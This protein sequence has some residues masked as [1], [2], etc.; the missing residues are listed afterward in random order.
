MWMLAAWATVMVVCSIL[1]YASE[2]G[3]NQAF[4]DPLDAL[5]WGISTLTTVGY[6][7]VYPVTSEGRLAAMT[8][9]ILGIGLYSA[10]TAA[11]TSYFV[12]G[13]RQSDVADELERLARLHDSGKLTEGEYA[14]AKA[15]VLD[16]S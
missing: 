12:A 1:L 14:S 5:W 2:V 4:D 7:D 16:T 11:I 8:L 15:R 6:G 3:L 9:M 13:D 10:I